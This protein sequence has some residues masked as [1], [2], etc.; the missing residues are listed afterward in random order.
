M[1]I[2]RQQ[3]ETKNRDRTRHLKYGS[4]VSKVMEC[5]REYSIGD[6]IRVSDVRKKTGITSLTRVL[7][8]LRRD[9]FIDYEEPGSGRASYLTILRKI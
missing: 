7:W 8:V 5:L 2:L 3:P 6:K 1:L 4:S 9:G